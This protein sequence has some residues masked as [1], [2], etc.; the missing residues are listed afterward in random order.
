MS[1]LIKNNDFIRNKIEECIELRLDDINDLFEVS[2]NEDYLCVDFIKKLKSIW[3]K[4]NKEP[5]LY[6]H[7]LLS[8]TELYLPCLEKAV[9]VIYFRIL[10]NHLFLFINSFF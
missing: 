7:Q 10:K 2:L 5:K 4:H 1:K 6:I 3:N 9:R 8:T